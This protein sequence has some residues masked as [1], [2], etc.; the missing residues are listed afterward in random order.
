MRV[1]A[2]DD[3]A[4]DGRLTRRTLLQRAAGLG[5]AASTL[6]ALDL[7]A[8]TPTREAIAA[9]SSL[10]EIQFQIERFGPRPIRVEGVKARMPP[11]Y[12]TFATFTLTRT[13]TA[14]DQATLAAALA[15]GE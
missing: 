1:D 13:P 10:P 2:H 6:G 12:T 5:L 8:L 15:K 14:A 3:A 7:L 9:S 4:G 11:V